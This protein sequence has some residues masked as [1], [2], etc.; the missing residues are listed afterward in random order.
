[1]H[2]QQLV[3]THPRQPQVDRAVLVAGIEALYDCAQSCTACADACLGEAQVQRLRHCIRLCGCL[4]DNRP[5]PLAPD[6]A[7][8]GLGAESAPGVCDGLPRMRRRV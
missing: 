7:G 8:L 2:T 1:M 4:R 6:G 5:D 3:Q